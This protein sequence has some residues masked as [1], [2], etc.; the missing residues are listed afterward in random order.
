MDM[1]LA[2]MMGI[3]LLSFVVVTVD[4]NVVVVLM[5]VPKRTMGPL[6]ENTAALEVRDVVVIVDMN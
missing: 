5:S 1:C 2:P 6:A 4:Q 3:F